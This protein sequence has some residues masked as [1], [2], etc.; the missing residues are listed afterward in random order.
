MWH[1]LQVCQ[2]GQQLAASFLDIAETRH[3]F[4]NFVPSLLSA[5]VSTIIMVLTP[6]ADKNMQILLDLGR[7]P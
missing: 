7:D 1:I 4:R 6:N 2:A 3:D 5:V